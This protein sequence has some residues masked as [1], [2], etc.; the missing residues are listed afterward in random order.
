MDTNGDQIICDF[1]MVAGRAFLGFASYNH[2]PISFE[3]LTSK[4]EHADS[5]S[6]DTYLSDV[7]DLDADDDSDYA[8]MKNNGKFFTFGKLV[9]IEGMCES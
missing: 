9:N 5:S 2:G 3:D 1:N 6:V 4:L 7:L 8:R